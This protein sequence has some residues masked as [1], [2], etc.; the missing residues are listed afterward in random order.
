MS[1]L[2]KIDQCLKIGKKLS[3]RAASITNACVAL[4]AGLKVRVYIC[5][6]CLNYVD[7]IFLLLNFLYI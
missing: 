2:N 7:G 6:A 4:L 3:W 1:L 5:L